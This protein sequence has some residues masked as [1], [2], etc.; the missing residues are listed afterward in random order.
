MSKV[1]SDSS[2]LIWNGGRVQKVSFLYFKVYFSQSFFRFK[3]HDHCAMASSFIDEVT[4]LWRVRKT[5]TRLQ[6]CGCAW[7]VDFVRFHSPETMRAHWGVS[8]ERTLVLKCKISMLE[9]TWIKF[10]SNWSLNRNP[11][12]QRLNDRGFYVSSKSRPQVFF[13]L[14][15]GKHADNHLLGQG[16]EDAKIHSPKPT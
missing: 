5:V 13:H 1:K 8:N 2:T 14:A 3:I 9:L 6:V 10:D 15:N 12:I 7:F 11:L 16:V 4:K